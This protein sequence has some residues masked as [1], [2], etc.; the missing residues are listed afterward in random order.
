VFN[1]GIN[2]QQTGSGYKWLTILQS[3]HDEEKNRA[4]MMDIIIRN[5][6][7]KL[8]MLQT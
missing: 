3:R 2:N 8:G 6:K 1:F 4:E 5:T 7:A